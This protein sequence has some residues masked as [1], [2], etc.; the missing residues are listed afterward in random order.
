MTRLGIELEEQ[1][2]RLRELF[3]RV[4]EAVAMVDRDFRITRINP[5]F[6]K[7]FGYTAEFALRAVSSPGPCGER[8]WEN[9][10]GSAA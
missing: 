2:A 10:A 9:Q 7:I 6:T 5:E 8:I 1:V 3:A 4:P